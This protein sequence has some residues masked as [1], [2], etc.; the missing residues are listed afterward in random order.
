MEIPDSPTIAPPPRPS[1]CGTAARQRMNA[2]SSA[3]DRIS[4]HSASDISRNGR[5]PPQPRIA[6]QDIDAAER[7]DRGFDHR[8][9]GQSVGHIRQAADRL[10]ARGFDLSH[11]AV[12]GGPI[13]AP[14]D[15]QGCSMRGQ[16]QGDRAADVLARTRDQG[17]LTREAHAA[18]RI[19]SAPF[20]A[21]MMTVALVL[22][23][24]TVGIIEASITRSPLIPFTFRSISTT[25]FGPGPIM[26]VLV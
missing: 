16:I 11:H 10:A 5:L 19:M 26:Q 15:H 14:V 25:E 12:D 1:I 13:G 17:D 7:R 22:P 9:G 20:S 21:I 23:E 18:R 6:D 2:P 4:R 8:R 24:T 3:T